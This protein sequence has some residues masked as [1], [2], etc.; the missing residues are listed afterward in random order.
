M[1]SPT[2]RNHLFFYETSSDKQRVFNI[3]IGDSSPHGSFHDECIRAA[4]LIANQFNN[5]CIWITL[6]GGMDSEV[7]ARSFLK[8]GVNIKC[9]IMAFENNLND[10]DIK[11]ALAFCNEQNIPYKIFNLNLENF[12]KHK[13]HLLY[14][15]EFKCSSPQIATHL[16]LA[17]NLPG[18]FVFSGSPALLVW[19]GHVPFASNVKTDINNYAFLECPPENNFC[20]D[21]LIL[22]RE[23]K[24]ISNFFFYT[25][26]LTM[27]ATNSFSNPFLTRLFY[28]YFFKNMKRLYID[29]NLN[30]YGFYTI[31]NSIKFQFYYSA[32]FDVLIRP[33]KYTGFEK[34][35]Y[36]LGS[37]DLL[38]PHYR[39]IDG[40]NQFNKLYRKP[41]EVIANQTPNIYVKFGQ[42]NNRM[43]QNKTQPWLSELANVKDWVLRSLKDL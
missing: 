5:E 28:T 25:P 29:E 15:R 38:D 6:S 43:L 2:Y 30:L 3:S 16:W 39:Q 32:G 4:R 17:E 33:N 13:S 24:G 12:Y 41:M 34:L 42:S 8:A 11:Y 37:T 9:A 18:P 26:E 14:A 10:H 19:S 21:R 36:M 31:I 22:K 23:L 35:H 40:L 27:S 1:T 7:V 20:L